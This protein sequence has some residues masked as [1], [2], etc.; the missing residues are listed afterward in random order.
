MGGTGTPRAALTA[1]SS[2]F[3]IGSSRT[4]PLLGPMPLARHLDLALPKSQ[5]MR[6][7]LLAPTTAGTSGDLSMQAPL[8]P[9]PLGSRS[10]SFVASGGGLAGVAQY[11][12]LPAGSPNS[13]MLSHQ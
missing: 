8:T 3:A 9:A 1:R 13:E 2:S 12:V 5:Q 10:S 7:S 4:Q 11:T 6:T